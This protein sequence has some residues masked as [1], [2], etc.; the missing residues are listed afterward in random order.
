MSQDVFLAKLAE[1]LHIRK[2]DLNEQS[3]LTPPTGIF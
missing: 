1:I 3:K 2:E